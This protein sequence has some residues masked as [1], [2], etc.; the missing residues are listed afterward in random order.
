MFKCEY[1][2]CD[3]VTEHRSAIHYHHIIPIEV[4]GTDAEYNRIYLCPNHHNSI[5]VPSSKSG[6]H[7][8]NKDGV[9]LI[10]KVYSTVGFLL[11]YKEN[12]EIKYYD[13]KI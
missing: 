11:E 13:F 9:I 7:S 2:N 12:G 5:Y 10:R 8:I 6:I 1:P 3:Y 4:N